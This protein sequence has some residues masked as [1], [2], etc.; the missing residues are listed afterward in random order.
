MPSF[1]RQRITNRRLYNFHGMPTVSVGTATQSSN[2]TAQ[3]NAFHILKIKKSGQVFAE[4]H[5]CAGSGFVRDED[6]SRSG[7]LN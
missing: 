5:M 3:P 7:P 6:R 1:E 4:H 2:G